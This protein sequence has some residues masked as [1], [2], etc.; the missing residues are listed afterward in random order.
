MD[1]FKEE[2]KERNA[3]LYG[4]GGGETH[5]VAFW[6]LGVHLNRYSGFY[7][8]YVRSATSLTSLELLILV[9]VYD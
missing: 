3:S 4:R 6:G 7:L 1:L 5:D 8:E 2:K 9:T